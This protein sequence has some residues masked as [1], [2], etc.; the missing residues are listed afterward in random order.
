MVKY[1][2]CKIHSKNAKDNEL[3]TPREYYK[4]YSFFVLPC[5]ALRTSGTI[6]QH[7]GEL[8]IPKRRRQAIRCH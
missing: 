4:N 3:F 5:F 8:N 2:G 6:S 1:S 7:F